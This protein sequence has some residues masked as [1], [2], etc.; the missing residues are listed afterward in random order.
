MEI[1]NLGR[2]KIDIKGSLWRSVILSTGQED[3]INDK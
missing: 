2:K 1:V 3:F